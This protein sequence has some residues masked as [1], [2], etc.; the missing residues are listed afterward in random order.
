MADWTSL[1]K[2]NVGKL[3]E[4]AVRDKTKEKIKLKAV[5]DQATQE[6]QPTKLAERVP[7]KGGKATQADIKAYHKGLEALDAKATEAA[8]MKAYRKVLGYYDKDKSCLRGK[9]SPTDAL[10]QLAEIKARYASTGGEMMCQ[11]FFTKATDLAEVMLQSF[12]ALEMLQLKPGFSNELT[13]MLVRDP[14]FYEPELTELRLETGRFEAEWQ[15][16][17]LAKWAGHWKAWS[18]GQITDVTDKPVVV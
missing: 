12:N 6:N 8:K 9:P 15:W 1:K 16:R 14:G 18:A 7:Q 3:S 17:L 5:A 10:A 2:S 13:A 4:Q 11:Q